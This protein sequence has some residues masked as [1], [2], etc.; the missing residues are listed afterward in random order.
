[1]DGFKIGIA[2]A[3]IQLVTGMD[4]T[5]FLARSSAST[6]V[7]DDLKTRCIFID[8]GKAQFVL[9]VNDLLALDSLFAGECISKAATMLGICKEH[10]VIACTHTHSGPASIFLQDCGEVTDSWLESLKTSILQCV[11]KA[12]DNVKL[13]TISY[14]TAH[15]NIGFNRVVKDKPQAETLI[16]NQVGIIEIR[17]SGTDLVDAVIVNYACHPVVLGGSLYS[18][19]FPHFT[20]ERVKQKPDYENA[21]IIYVSGCCGDINP[22]ERGDLQKAKKLGY[23]LADSIDDASV[24]QLEQK[25]FFKESLQIRS[26]KVEIP[27]EHDLNKASVAKLQEKYAQSLE[28]ESR[29]DS[30]GIGVKVQSSYLHWVENMLNKMNNGT[31]EKSVCADIKIIGIGAL[32]VVTLPFEVFH[33][34]GLKIKEHFGAD[35]TI[36]I[37]YANGDFGYLPSKELYTEAKAGYEAGL[38]FKYYGYPGPVAK[39]AEDI[40]LNEIFKSG[41]G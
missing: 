22:I 18:K 33:Q 38:A 29:K 40:L 2:V 7:H 6:G 19:D 23:K 21:E 15:C 11:K 25:A 12:S 39:N 17:D 28:E 41:G 37:C 27:L 32:T 35:R 36:V 10:I 13:S 26:L 16:D 3:D 31:L 14:K 9:V 30:N 20:M 1:M 34:I 4:M 8:D 5:G 24:I